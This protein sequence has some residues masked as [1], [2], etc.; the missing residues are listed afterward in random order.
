MTTLLQTIYDYA[1]KDRAP[2]F[3]V[4]GEYE[5]LSGIVEQ[6][7]KRVEALLPPGDAQA[8]GNFQGDSLL[9]RSMELEAMFRAGLSL[10]LELSRL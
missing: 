4:G 6:Q 2:A 1:Q 5:E 3:L 9:L 10:G 7:K 8:W